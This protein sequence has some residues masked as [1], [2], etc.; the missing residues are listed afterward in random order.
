M[1]VKFN[2][3]VYSEEAITNAVGALTDSLESGW[4]VTGK[5]IEEAEAVV[6]SLFKNKGKAVGFGIAPFFPVAAALAEWCHR[7]GKPKTVAV[8]GTAWPEHIACF[9]AFGFSVRVFDIDKPEEFPSISWEAV[10]KVS[11]W[12][13]PSV[14]FV[15]DV[16]GVAPGNLQ[17]FYAD[18]EWH[19]ALMVHDA[20]YGF[21][22]KDENPDTKM[23]EHTRDIGDIVTMSLNP[24]KLITGLNGG[25]AFTEDEEIYDLM[26]VARLDGLDENKNCYM[27]VGDWR[28]LEVQASV[29]KSSLN[30]A[31]TLR[32]KRV[33]IASQYD[34]A[35]SIN[36][37]LNKINKP[38]QW[39]KSGMDRYTLRVP[40]GRKY[41]LRDQMNEAGIQSVML[42]YDIAALEHKAVSL[43]AEQLPDETPNAVEWCETHILIPLHNRMTDKDVGYVANFLAEEALLK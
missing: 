14:V 12:S 28:M 21:M 8:Q 35:I 42:T 30:E 20:S 41:D 3:T 5:E 25:M 26:K 24:G 33:S 17:K 31:P 39:L 10:D 34:E 9:K 4:V 7:K 15:A 1:N 6:A 22:A 27:L 37:V 40:R 19:G 29:L 23:M 16:H 36:P 32:A 13:A 18:C 11:S 43:A 38:D 2:E